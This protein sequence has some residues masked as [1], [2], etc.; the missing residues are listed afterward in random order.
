MRFGYDWFEAFRE[1][2]G[3]QM[4]V[5]NGEAYSP[6]GELVRDLIAIVTV[7]S[8]RFWT[9]AKPLPHALRAGLIARVSRARSEATRA[10]IAALDQFE[11]GDHRI[12]VPKLGFIGG[13]ACSCS[14]VSAWRCRWRRLSLLTRLALQ[15]PSPEH[16]G[17]T[18]GSPGQN[19]WFAMRALQ[20]LTR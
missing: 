5:M 4:T 11:L 1:R 6:E 15:L 9:W 2:H 19:G 3:T 10:S 17:R 14:L 8:A 20:P 16:S 18:I 7:I 12:R 13:R